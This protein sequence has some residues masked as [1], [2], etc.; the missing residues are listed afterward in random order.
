MRTHCSYPSWMGLQIPCSSL[1]P[2]CSVCPSLWWF[3]IF[4]DK[5]AFTLHNSP[6]AILALSISSY[7]VL[8][9][10]LLGFV[11]SRWQLL[12]CFVL[13]L[14]VCLN[15]HLKCCLPCCRSGLEVYQ[16]SSLSFKGMDIYSDLYYL[17]P[18]WMVSHLTNHLRACLC[19]SSIP[20][21]ARTML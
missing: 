3:P 19:L 10:L 18:Y 6:T 8:N 16:V 12:T 15:K 7:L 13:N 14:Q 20:A 17:M 9:Y 2:C 5:L 21:Y 11:G 4:S 1:K